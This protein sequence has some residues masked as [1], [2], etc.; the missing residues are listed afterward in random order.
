MRRGPQVGFHTET[1]GVENAKP[2][3]R[4]GTALRSAEQ[5]PAPSFGV[6]AFT[7]QAA[8]IH[9]TGICLRV[10][11]SLFGRRPAPA[12]RFG[13]V[14]RH[15]DAIRKQELAIAQCGCP[16]PFCT[17]CRPIAACPS[18]MKQAELMLCSGVSALRGLPIIPR[19]IGEVGEHAMPA[20][21]E[22]SQPIERLGMVVGCSRRPLVQRRG[23]VRTL[24]GC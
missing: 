20:R 13:M 22:Q 8:R 9:Q 15:V 18:E 23:I 14:L 19:G 11:H 5:I 16:V 21:I 6:I 4:R 12:K 24:V 1:I 17:A 7:A 2:E 3:F 10:G